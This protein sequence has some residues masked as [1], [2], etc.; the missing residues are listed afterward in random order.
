MLFIDNKY[1]RIYFRLIE[2]AR[3]RTLE[4]YRERHHIKHRHFNKYPKAL[5]NK[6]LI[7]A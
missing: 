4:G 2:R 3:T 1:S 6:I 5:E 7:A